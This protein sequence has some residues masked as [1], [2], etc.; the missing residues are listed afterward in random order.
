MRTASSVVAIGW[1]AVFAPAVGDGGSNVAAESRWYHDREGDE[2]WVCRDEDGFVSRPLPD[3]N[4]TTWGT[5]YTWREMQEA[6]GLMGESRD[7]RRD[8]G[9]CL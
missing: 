7:R 6:L 1:V 2:W 9:S 4:I 5:G 8:A 3:G